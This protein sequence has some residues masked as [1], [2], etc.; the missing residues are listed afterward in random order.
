MNIP[1]FLY[2]DGGILI[3]TFYLYF[4]A[5]LSFAMMCASLIPT[6]RI[7]II[8]GFLLLLVG[9]IDCSIYD[10]ASTYSNFI[11]II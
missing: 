7:A 9:L 3:L 2:T 4:L 1:F 5:M 8:I 11:I 10:F 6:S